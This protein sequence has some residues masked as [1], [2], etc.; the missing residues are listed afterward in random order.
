MVLLESNKK[1]RIIYGNI[2]KK[3]NTTIFVSENDFASSLWEQAQYSHAII[4]SIQNSCV[5]GKPFLELFAYEDVSLYWFF[6]HFYWAKLNSTIKFL[7]AFLKFT[8]QTTPETIRIEDDFDKYDIIKQICHKKKINFEYSKLNYLKFKA[9]DRIGRHIRK[10]RLQ[11]ITKLKIKN[12]KNLYYKK[13]RSIHSVNSKVVFASAD[14]YRRYIINLDKG[15]TEEGEFLVQDIISL[16]KNKK[17]VVGI[18]LDYDV[19]GNIK[20]LSQ[21]L[22]SEIPWLP[23]EILMNNHNKYVEHKEFL[24]KYRKL[25]AAKE[26]Q[27]LFEFEGISLWNELRKVF[28]QMKY[29]P[30]LPF[31]LDLIDSLLTFFS[32]N[33]PKIVFLPYE[34]GPLALALIISCKRFSIKTIGIQHGVIADNWRFYT[35]SPLVTSENPYG[36]PFPD[37]EL[38]FGEFSK[39]LLLKNGYPEERLISFGNPVFF[40]LDKKIKFLANQSLYKKYNVSENQK[41]ILFTTISLQK[42]KSFAKQNYN[43]EIWHCLLKNFAGNK[44]FCIILKPHQDETTAIYEKI[45]QDYDS[46]NVRI[47]QGSLYGLAFISTVVVSIFS[48]AIIDSLCFK[49]PVIE[50]QFE[51]IGS[52]IPFDKWGVVLSVKVS[53][54]SKK[55]SEILNNEEIKNNII[56][57][58][59]RFLKNLYNI[60]EDNPELEME[61]ILNE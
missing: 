29:A 25:I 36:F 54:I 59:Q 4:K 13:F 40:K 33:K 14:V 42:F 3:E 31:W 37:K 17:D 30:Y 6:Y 50:V 10:F 32:T 21:R 5:M 7:N 26:F 27:K 18:A 56:K 60:P 15:V 53:D 39:Q 44:D 9:R 11:K 20:K 48:T 47:I 1:I 12:R 43:T 35:I 8:E 57:N 41:V 55:I 16:L 52:P 58:S 28:E 46:S 51:N 49:K 2:S 45:L 34:A 38:L 61:K 22:E 19:R 23:L 24:N